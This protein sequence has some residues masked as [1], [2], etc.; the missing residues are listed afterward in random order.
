MPKL[1]EVSFLFKRVDFF[2]KESMVIGLFIIA[3]GLIWAGEY[4]N[5]E[6]KVP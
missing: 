6:A 4:S 2:L 1:R 3:S 5:A